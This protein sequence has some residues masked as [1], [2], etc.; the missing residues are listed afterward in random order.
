[1]T[2]FERIAKQESNEYTAL[3]LMLSEISGK[4]NAI[5]DLLKV[6]RV[7]RIELIPEDYME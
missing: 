3:I 7:E 2:D 1:M 5:I 4:L 6:K